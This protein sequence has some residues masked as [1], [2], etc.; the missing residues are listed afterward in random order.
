MRT[1]RNIKDRN[2]SI[3]WA[4]NALKDPDIFVIMDTET[5][6]LAKTDVI[7]QIAIIDLNGSTLIDTLVKPT[8]RKRM[9][10][11]AT[12]VHGITMG[13]LK[14]APY[15][16][17]IMDNLIKLTEGK[18]VIIYN[19]R[20]DT[21]MIV[22]TCAYDEIDLRNRK[23]YM[24]CEC[25]M[26]LYSRFVGDWSDYH[27]DYKFHRLPH[28]GHSAIDDCNATLNL[29]K[30]IAGAEITEEPVVAKPENKW[31]QFWK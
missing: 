6:G 14:S 26:V 23:W 12:D 8:K 20:F 9:S 5:T 4:R 1:H 10:P 25:A 31:W 11:G 21:Q 7:I 16:V 17:E 27:N 22:Q 3:T 18:K 30:F 13:M 29:I 15:F 2:E 28:A 19:A 24:D